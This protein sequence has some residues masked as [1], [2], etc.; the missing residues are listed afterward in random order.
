MVWSLSATDRGRRRRETPAS[1][2][3]LGRWAKSA[4]K[5]G[6]PCNRGPARKV[7]SAAWQFAGEWSE[8]AC[9]ERCP[10]RS[11]RGSA[12]QS[13]VIRLFPTTTTVHPT[14]SCGW[15]ERWSCL[16]G[17]QETLEIEMVCLPAPVTSLLSRIAERSA[18][19]SPPQTMKLAQH[20]EP[21][22]TWKP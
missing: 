16:R 6:T 18:E 10:L 21:N 9:R 15:Y 4:A 12:S 13:R 8:S 1:D 7:R 19:D 14:S 17:I 22:P 20:T 11:P 3:W 5:V 2:G